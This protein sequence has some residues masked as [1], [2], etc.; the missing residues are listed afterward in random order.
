MSPSARRIHNNEHSDSIRVHARLCIA[1]S[2]DGRPVR[3]CT[4]DSPLHTRSSIIVSL[5]MTT[6]VMSRTF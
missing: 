1:V 3:H 4:G 6:L 5:N 2:Y